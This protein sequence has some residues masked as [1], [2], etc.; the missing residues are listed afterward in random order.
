[1]EINRKGRWHDEEDRSEVEEGRC[2]LERR[3]QAENVAKQMR[4][5]GRGKQSK[6]R[7]AGLK[8]EYGR[9]SRIGEKGGIEDEEDWGKRV[10]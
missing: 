3:G 9:K 1:M 7:N 5:E 10:I 6:R 4:K 2:S 8:K